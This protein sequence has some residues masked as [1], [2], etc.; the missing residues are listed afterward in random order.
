MIFI[1]L[2]ALL[3]GGIVLL[4]R[5]GDTARIAELAREGG[6]SDAR[7]GWFSMS[8]TWRGYRTRWSMR[9]G[10]RDQRGD[11]VTP[12]RVT[13][14]IAVAASARNEATVAELAATLGPNDRLDIKP[15]LVRVVIVMEGDE[16][17]GIAFGH[18][19]TCATSAI[20]RLSLPPLR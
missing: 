8:G 2:L 9:G 10:K 18:A 3:A 12:L 7:A 5:R 11:L 19:W 13:V 14:D 20:E 4:E 15:S 17:A 1:A 16:Q 6:I